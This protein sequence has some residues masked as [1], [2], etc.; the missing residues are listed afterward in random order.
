MLS[1][2]LAPRVFAVEQPAPVFAV[3]PSP[4]TEVVDETVL[5][6]RLGG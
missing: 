5:F 3:V 2:Y 6:T 1:A 4:A